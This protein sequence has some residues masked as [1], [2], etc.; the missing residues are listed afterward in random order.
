MYNCGSWNKLHFS[1]SFHRYMFV[2]IIYTHI[3]KHS[4]LSV[5]HIHTSVRLLPLTNMFN[6]NYLQLYTSLLF[7][8]NRITRHNSQLFCFCG[9]NSVLIVRECRYDTTVV[10]IFNFITWLHLQSIFDKMF[11]FCTR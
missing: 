4:I 1:F 8:F 6:C 10:L 2:L 7:E 5:T 3:D 11:C 9:M